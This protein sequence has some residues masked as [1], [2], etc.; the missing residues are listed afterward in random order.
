MAD[1][2]A[3]ETDSVM[4]AVGPDGEPPSVET[5]VDRLV[6]AGHPRTPHLVAKVTR[7]RASEVERMEFARLFAVP[8]AGATRD[9]VSAD[10]GAGVAPPLPFRLRPRRGCRPCVPRQG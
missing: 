3:T 5:L 9:A 7:Y 4:Q 6:A 8:A 10:T 2:A 1:D